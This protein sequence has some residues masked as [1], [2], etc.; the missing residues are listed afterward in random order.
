M[1]V[2]I[3]PDAL[4]ALGMSSREQSIYLSALEMGEALQM[5]LAQKARVKRTTLRELLPGLL[6]RGI[7]VQK[8]V[9]KRKLLLARDPRELLAELEEKTKK[10]QEAL[11]Q[12][13]AL[14]NIMTDKPEVRFYE[15]IEGLKQIYQLTLD[16]GLTMY[17]FV[18]AEYMYPE[19]KKWL[20][21]YYIP[22]KLRRKIWIY[23]IMTEGE[24]KLLMPEHG[25]RENKY[26]PKN[27]YPFETEI[28]TFGDYITFH[29]FRQDEQPSAILIK[30]KA[31]AQTLF[32]IHKLLWSNLP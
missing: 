14:Q 21:D 11:P 26:I 8:V 30:S 1:A 6:D 4:S 12:L 10:A 13:I 5:P 25:Y 16:V 32:S 27:Q 29:N 18:N 7:L 23:N 20:A 31:A 17:C 19:L 22:E 9:G 24:T 2:T 15:G 28:V 3:A